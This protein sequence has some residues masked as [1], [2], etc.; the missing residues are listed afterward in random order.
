[1]SNSLEVVGAEFGS[2]PL[3][4]GGVWSRGAPGRLGEV[5]AGLEEPL[6]PL[7]S[8][9]TTVVEGPQPFG[10][11]GAA[12][13]GTD[14]E[15]RLVGE[16]AGRSEVGLRSSL[17]APVFD[18][19]FEG[20]A[21][22]AGSVGVSESEGAEKSVEEGSGLARVPVAVVGGR[23]GEVGIGFL[24][25]CFV[26]AAGGELLGGPGDPELATGL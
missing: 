20:D 5:G 14:H 25:R 16:E 7:L 19:G 15:H 26:D 6:D 10:G 23:E 12:E 9:C 4:G 17:D 2:D 8:G 11:C 22:E 3:N 21:F 13:P 18:G 24:P 1:V